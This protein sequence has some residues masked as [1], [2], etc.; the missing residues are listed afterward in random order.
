MTD[1]LT[2]LRQASLDLERRLAGEH[3]RR[4]S[5][6]QA[7]DAHL[8]GWLTRPFGIESAAQG[9][10]A[11]GGFGMELVGQ[12]LDAI[13]VPGQ[14]WLKVIEL[15]RKD[16]LDDVG[17]DGFFAAAEAVLEGQGQMLLDLQ[18][19]TTHPALGKTSCHWA[20]GLL[21]VTMVLFFS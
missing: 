18:R 13:T 15:S 9:Q 3:H 16:G 11:L 8:L 19:D 12:I 10:P 20:N 17:G 4:N 7:G 5:Q 2:K 14:P 21:V 1:D 6:R